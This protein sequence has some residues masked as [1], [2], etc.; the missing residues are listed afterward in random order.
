M[1]RFLML[2]PA[3]ITLRAENN[4]GVTAAHADIQAFLAGATVI[5]DVDGS[6]LA[7]THNAPAQFPVGTTTVQFSARD[8][9]GNIGYAQATVNVVAHQPVNF[10]FEGIGR[11]PAGLW[12]LTLLLMY[13]RKNK[14]VSP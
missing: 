7:I 14:E 3:D 11:F 1:V 9:T 13:L 6:L 5:D 12:L 8:S 4:S 2:P 10:A